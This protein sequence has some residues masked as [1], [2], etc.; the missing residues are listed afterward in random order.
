MKRL[1]VL[2]TAV[3]VTTTVLFWPSLTR[4]GEGDDEENA[5]VDTSTGTSAESASTSTS[6]S[7]YDVEN[8]RSTHKEDFPTEKVDTLTIELKVDE[9]WY[10]AEDSSAVIIDT[11]TGTSAEDTSTNTSTSPH[12]V[13]ISGEAAKGYSTESLDTSTSTDEANNPTE[14]DN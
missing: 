4:A 10:P 6:K 1:M 8:P 3:L 11:S 7:Q 5:D 13:D 9:S 14:E 2:L 12:E